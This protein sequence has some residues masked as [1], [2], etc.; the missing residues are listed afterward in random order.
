MLLGRRRCCCSGV[1]GSPPSPPRLS[2]FDGA[3][4]FASWFAPL[5][6]H[7]YFYSV[8]RYGMVLVEGCMSAVQD[9][10]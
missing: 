3:F 9:L 7:L 10:F 6:F 1:V 2:A 4:C 5:S 8:P